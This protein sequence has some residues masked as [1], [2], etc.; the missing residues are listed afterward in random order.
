MH[1]A[2]VSHVF[3]IRLFE[4]YQNIIEFLD[5][6]ISALNFLLMYFKPMV[7]VVEALFMMFLPHFKPLK[8]GLDGMDGTAPVNGT[9]ALR[10]PCHFPTCFL[11]ILGAAVMLDNCYGRAHLS[12]S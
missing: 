6:R 2:G 5:E 11:Y 10:F 3:H 4:H 8:S 9:D 12:S 1:G 7:V